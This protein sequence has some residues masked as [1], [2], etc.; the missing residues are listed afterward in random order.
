[1]YQVFWMAFLSFPMVLL[2]LLP[3]SLCLFLNIRQASFVLGVPP[4][5]DCLG[6]FVVT[7]QQLLAPSQAKLAPCPVSCQFL[8]YAKAACHCWTRV[9][10]GMAGMQELGIFGLVPPAGWVSSHYR[11]LWSQGY[12]A[13]DILTHQKQLLTFF[14]QLCLLS[15]S[16][17][18]RILVL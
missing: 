2:L 5:V 10:S 13:K 11:C 14:L 18:Y 6:H 9:S 15:I 8:P 1:M 7:K 16:W 3:N 4:Y 12:P 17:S